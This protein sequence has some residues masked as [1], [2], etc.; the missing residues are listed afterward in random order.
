MLLLVATMNTELQPLRTR[1]MSHTHA[2]LPAHC[3]VL[4]AY[5]TVTATGSGGVSE[6]VVNQLLTEMD[7]LEERRYPTSTT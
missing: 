3:V 4:I 5:Q 2:V 6:R 7:G 1:H